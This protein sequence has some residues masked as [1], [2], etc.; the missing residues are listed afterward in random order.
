MEMKKMIKGIKF[1]FF[2]DSVFFGYN[3]T[4]ELESKK[5]ELTSE[6]QEKT[7]LPHHWVD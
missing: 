7:H 2:D 4:P 1:N 5:S 6:N 3:K